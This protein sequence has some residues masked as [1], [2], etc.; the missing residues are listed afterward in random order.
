MLVRRS[1]E[2]LDRFLSLFLFL[3][4]SELTVVAKPVGNTNCSGFSGGFSFVIWWGVF[5]KILF[6]FF[7]N[8]YF[9]LVFCFADIHT[10]DN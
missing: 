3:E 2:K 9:P 6:F 4:R 1:G 7:F 8:L 5:P 10:K